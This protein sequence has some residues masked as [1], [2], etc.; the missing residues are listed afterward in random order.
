MLEKNH[1]FKEITSDNLSD[2]LKSRIECCICKMMSFSESVKEST[3]IEKS[4][5]VI[6]EC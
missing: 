1:I 4:K 5:V 3:K 2:V 6:L